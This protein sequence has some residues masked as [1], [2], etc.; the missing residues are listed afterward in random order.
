MSTEFQDKILKV[1]RFLKDRAL[2]GFLFST[3]PSFAWLTCGRDN[4]IRSDVEKGAAAIWVTPTAVE[5]WCD[6]IEEKR[7]REEETRGL[8]LKYR[9]Y[10]WYETG[11]SMWLK[12]KAA[13]DDAA[14]GTKYLKS[15]IARL[16][17]VLTG[18]E[19][20]RFRMVGR[21]SGQAMEEIGLRLKPGMREQQVAAE[22]SRALVSRGLEASVVLV[23]ADQRLLRYRHPIPTSNKIKKTVMMVVCAKG[24]GLIANLTRIVHFGKIPGDLRR[25]HEA[26]LKVECAMWEATAP[27]VQAKDVFQA[28]ILEYAR[29][30]FAGEWKKHHQG[31]PAGYETRDYL[32]TPTCTHRLLENQAMAW[33]PS[34]TGTKSEDTVLLTKKGLELLTSTPNWPM[35]K[36]KYDSKEFLR[37]DILT[38]KG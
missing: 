25:R 18:E 16:R 4:H 35:V 5:L 17:W 22:L 13:S 19:I 8:P 27:D 9:V 37:P 2:N 36:V 3:R 33:N 12:G 24:F 15:E 6:S 28:A 30:G 34:I 32:A 7:F 10:P 29:Q 14:N 21:L 38:V 23:G 20:K 11:I 31:G 26:C 1:R